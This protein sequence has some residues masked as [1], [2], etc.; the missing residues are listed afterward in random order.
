MVALAGLSER[1]L[2]EIMRINKEVQRSNHVAQIF[3]L[4]LDIILFSWQVVAS[5]IMKVTSDITG[6]QHSLTTLLL[7]QVKKGSYG[8]LKTWKVLQIVLFRIWKV[9]EFYWQSWKDLENYKL[10]PLSS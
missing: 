8:F 6:R 5:E 10:L 1:I 2:V 4:L 3:A 9:M 7:S